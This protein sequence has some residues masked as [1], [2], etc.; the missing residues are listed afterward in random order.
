MPTRPLTGPGFGDRTQTRS[1]TIPTFRSAGRRPKTSSGSQTFRESAGRRRWCGE[2]RVFITAATSEQRMKPPSLGTEF[3][4]EYIAELRKQGLSADEINKRLWARDRE[5]PE[6]IVISLMLFCYDLESGKRLWERQ[7][8]HGQPAGRTPR[9][10]QLCVRD[11]GHRRRA[12]LCVP[13]RLRPVRLRFRGE[14]SLGDA[15]RAPR[16][17][18]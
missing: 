12:R 3:S 2:H 17:H 7:I 10:E 8:Y 16:D 18:P 14:T 1:P 9:Q 4:N 6:D 11:A 5:M 15:V 13:Y